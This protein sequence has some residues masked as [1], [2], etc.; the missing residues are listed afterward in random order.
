MSRSDVFRRN[1][2]IKHNQLISNGWHGGTV[3]VAVGLAIP[4]TGATMAGVT[5]EKRALRTNPSIHQQTGFSGDGRA[6]LSVSYTEY[7]SYSD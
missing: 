3:R 7:A 1:K 5:V 2:S 6:S 4:A